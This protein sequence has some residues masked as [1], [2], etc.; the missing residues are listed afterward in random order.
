M[1]DLLIDRLCVRG[2]G[3][4]CRR[5][6]AAW[7]RAARRGGVVCPTSAMA[8]KHND[9]LPMIA[10]NANLIEPPLKPHDRGADVNELKNGPHC[11]VP[12]ADTL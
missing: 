3:V 7:P 2:I 1:A 12:V 6:G 8:T 11:D 10:G 4:D 9:E 5:T